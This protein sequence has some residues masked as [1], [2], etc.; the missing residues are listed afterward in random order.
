M[1]VTA[2]FVSQAHNYGKLQP[3]SGVM[4]EGCVRAEVT[5][6]MRLCDKHTMGIA[7]S[8]VEAKTFLCTH[9]RI[10]FWTDLFNYFHE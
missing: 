8:E 9:E 5:R 3:I 7:T 2:E 10:S 6:K 1:T 4:Q